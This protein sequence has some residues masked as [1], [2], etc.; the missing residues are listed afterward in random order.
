M[1]KPPISRRTALGLV[2]I[3]VTGGV[4]LT[5]RQFRRANPAIAAGQP[6]ITGAGVCRIMPEVTEG[7]Y[8][9]DPKLVRADITE[10]RPG[11][12]LDLRIQVVDAACLPIP[13]ARVDIWHCDAQGIYSGFPNQ[14]GGTDTT[15]QTFLRGTQTGDDE[16]IA[17][18]ETIYP[19]WYPGRTP[20][21]HF[22]AFPNVNEVLTGQLFFPDELSKDIYSTVEA[23]GGRDL[24]G[25]T[26][27]DRD[28]IA[29]Q[30]GEAAHAQMNR[31]GEALSAALV[32][33]VGV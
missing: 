22:K 4:F 7:P 8:Y 10:A 27:N 24:A 25:A 33:A 14:L 12:S 19:G 31:S 2:A 28:G 6:L 16:G 5:A 26:F 1:K 21:I 20:H 9:I 32:V 13:G 11:V 29:R 23:Y 17:A 3:T 30:A 15:G 18:F